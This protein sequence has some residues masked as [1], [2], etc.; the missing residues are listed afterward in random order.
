[1]PVQRPQSARQLAKNS[2]TTV[3]TPFILYG[4]EF[5]FDSQLKTWMEAIFQAEASRYERTGLFSASGT[6]LI[7]QPP[8]VQHNT[9]VSDGRLWAAVDDDGNLSQKPRIVSTATAFA[10]H[11]LFPNSRYS[12]DL[13]LSTLDL[14][15]PTLGYYEGFYERSGQSV[16]GFTTATNSLILQALLHSNTARQP[17][18]Q[19]HNLKK[20]LWWQTLEAG[21]TTD[22]GLPKTA[23]PKIQ[24]SNS[25]GDAFWKDIQEPAQLSISDQSPLTLP[26]QP[27]QEPGS[28]SGPDRPLLQLPLSSPSQLPDPEDRIAAKLA[29]NYFE[30]NL[31]PS[32]GLVNSVD[33]LAWGTWWDQGSAILGLHAGYQLGLVSENKFDGLI[34]RLLETLETM[35]LPLAQLPSKAYST[36]AGEMRTLENRA[37][38]QGS[39][40]WSALDLSR[41]LIALHALKTHYRD[42]GEQIDRIVSRYRLDKLVNDGWLWGSGAG[43]AGLQYWQEGRLGYEQYAARGLALWGIKADKAL[44]YPPKQTVSVDGVSLEID[45][46]D[47][48]S[49]GASNYL[50]SDPYLLWGMELGWPDALLPQINSLLEVQAN[51]YERTGILTA[52]NEDSLDR[53]PYFLYYSVYADGQP[54]TALSTTGRQ[55]Q[56]LRFLSTKAAFSWYS[57]FPDS[58]YAKRLRQSVQNLADAKRGYLSGRYEAADLGPNKAVNINTNAVILESLLY[59]ARAGQPLALSS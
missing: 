27:S 2:L 29:W 43:S 50:T 13:W 25:G 57:L 58:P 56:N 51:R 37:D 59:R 23:F 12:R 21:L 40:G 39:S 32:T 38:P 17:I 4:L 53:K 9:L 7:H 45:R 33:D 31:N 18:V 20:S 52:V 30:N 19:P 34:T 48:L 26:P 11:T 16:L 15:N 14:Y 5:G 42:Y 35:P 10:Y 3:S 46:R 1:M 36:A 28:V 22:R 44:F 8:Y 55:Y 41:Y 49:S 54:W 6:T 47:R 24:M